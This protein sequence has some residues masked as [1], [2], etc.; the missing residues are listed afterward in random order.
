MLTQTA[1]KVTSLENTS[2]VKKL[3]GEGLHLFHSINFILYNIYFLNYLTSI[4]HY[5]FLISVV[6]FFFWHY[7]LIDYSKKTDVLF[8]RNFL[9]SNVNIFLY[10][11][12][13]EHLVLYT[14]PLKEQPIRTGLPNL[15]AVNHT[16]R[17]L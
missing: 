12:L 2:F 5:Y 14:V 4:I 1:L 17:R 6:F 10:V 7:K 9:F 13:V 16:K 15:F 3:D 8:K 11:F